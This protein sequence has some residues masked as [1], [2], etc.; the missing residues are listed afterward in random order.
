MVLNIQLIKRK[1]DLLADYLRS[2]A[3]NILLVT[4]TWLTN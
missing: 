3:I 1:E 4:E 2:E